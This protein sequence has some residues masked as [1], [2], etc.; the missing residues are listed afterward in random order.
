[1]CNAHLHLRI[2]AKAPNRTSSSPKPLDKCVLHSVF[3]D[4]GS[5]FLE[6]FEFD[7]HPPGRDIVLENTEI[8]FHL[9][10]ANDERWL[11]T[12]KTLRNRCIS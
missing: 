10:K 9:R 6:N 7:S 1:M 11:L 8:Q 3:A 2:E 5:T 4:L 12:Y